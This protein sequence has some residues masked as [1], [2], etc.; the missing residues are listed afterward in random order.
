MSGAPFLAIRTERAALYII[1][2]RLRI[3]FFAFP[4]NVTGHKDL[5]KCIVQP[6]NTALLRYVFDIGTIMEAIIL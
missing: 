6:A 3:M 1:L 5:R 4:I 2:A